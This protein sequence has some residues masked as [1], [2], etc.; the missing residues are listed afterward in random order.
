MVFSPVRLNAMCSGVL[1]SELITHNFF[2]QHKVITGVQGELNTRD[3]NRCEILC[4][5]HILLSV[6]SRNLVVA[7]CYPFLIIQ[8]I[9][10]SVYA[11]MLANARTNHPALILTSGRNMARVLTFPHKNRLFP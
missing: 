3:Q 11:A 10:N 7:M 6:A 2:D 1:Q 9:V 4:R 5:R 8:S